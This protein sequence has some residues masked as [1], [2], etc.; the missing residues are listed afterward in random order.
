MEMQTKSNEGGKAVQAE[1]LLFAPHRK[2][3]LQLAP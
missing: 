2:V 1:P 3:L